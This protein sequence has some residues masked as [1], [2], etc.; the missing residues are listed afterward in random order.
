MITKWNLDAGDIE[1]N[2]G[3]VYSLLEANCQHF[4]RRVMGSLKNDGWADPSRLQEKFSLVAFQKT[5]NR[6][7]AVDA[8]TEAQRERGEDIQR[9]A[10]LTHQIGGGVGGGG[11]GIGHW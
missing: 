4:V 5:L 2:R 10:G 3:D 8:H 11:S 7:L 1:R 9:R 6:T